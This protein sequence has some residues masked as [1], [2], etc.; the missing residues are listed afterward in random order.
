MIDIS[1]VATGT[2]TALVPYLRKGIESFTGEA[3][4]TLW[5][6]L[7]EKFTARNKRKAIDELKEKPDEPIVQKNAVAALEEVLSE[8]PNL[9]TELQ[10]LVEAAKKEFISIRNSK[11]IN[12]GTVN[13]G[14][15]IIIG[16]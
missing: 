8:N 2:V 3:G 10:Q 5:K 12:T 1:V 7:E 13:A 14:G 9:K 4:K 11:N 16:D 15:N 6:W